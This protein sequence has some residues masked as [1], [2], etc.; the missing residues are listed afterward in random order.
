MRA[1]AAFPAALPHPGGWSLNLQS[2]VFLHPQA[3]SGWGRAGHP[4]RYDYHGST[5]S[6]ADSSQ[7]PGLPARGPDAQLCT[8]PHGT[9]QWKYTSSL[10][11]PSYLA[12]TFKI[13]KET[14]K[15]H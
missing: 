12:A 1:Q 10:R 9:V 8:L 5:R 3:C 2:S 7:P 6:P 13:T 15:V 4:E 14:R 11:G